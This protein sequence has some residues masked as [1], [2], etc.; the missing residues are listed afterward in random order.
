[1]ET[2]KQ[3]VIEQDGVLLHHCPRCQTYK[4]FE[5]FYVNRKTKTGRSVYCKICQSAY[6]KT[7]HWA[8]WR[9]ERYYRNPSRTIWIEARHRA[10][11]AGLP[12]N[13]EPEDC[14]I[15]EICPVLGIKMS[16]KGRGHM[17]DGTP[18][19]DKI[20][21]SQGYVKGN[22]RVISWK[23]NRLKSDCDDPAIFEL[24]AKYI[25][26]HRRGT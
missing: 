24:I 25:A 18:T 21:Q 12:F 22:V 9:K 20:I 8:E 6:A 19:L 7:P 10:K 11:K 14:V 17:D 3:R 16:P 26:E 13:I 1:M 23:A 15:P 2:R 5:E 4:S